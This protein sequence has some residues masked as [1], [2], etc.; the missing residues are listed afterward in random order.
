MKLL[1]P[2]DG[3]LSADAA[4]EDLPRAGIPAEAEALVVC[5]EDGH[6]GES[7]AGESWRSKLAQA[8]SLAEKAKTRIHF[9]FPRWTISSEALWGSPAKVIL[10]VADRWH[11]D[12]LVVG[13]HGRSRVARLFLGSVSLELI[14]K[15]LCSVRVVRSGTK[16]T[17]SD[18]IRIVIGDD[19]SA[20]AEA[21]VRA[22]A[23]RSW[24]PGTEARVVSVI[25]TLV[26]PMTALEAS[27]YAQEP[28]FDVIAQVDE[29]ERTRLRDV[30]DK[31]V[32]VLHRAGIAA[33]PAVIEG[34]PRE[35]LLTEAEVL[36]ADTIFVGARGL[37]RMER[38]L[39]G[40]VS[41]YIVTHAAATVVEVE[42][43]R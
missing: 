17:S 29:Q 43:A 25:Q 2:Y 7:S 22:I 27:T 31:A 10:D 16:R 14:H 4:L 19:G 32:D 37:G 1:I 34:D 15:A 42:R 9:L 30:A 35:V 6:L 39:L 24:P 11:P 21:M 33:K 28:A 41:S 23:S 40:S 18:P 5:V 8:E 26:P 12:L 36:N 20:E 3:S 38:L 13:S